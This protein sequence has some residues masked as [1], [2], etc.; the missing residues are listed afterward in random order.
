M[1]LERFKICS[2]FVSTRSLRIRGVFDES[3]QLSASTTSRCSQ[4]RRDFQNLKNALVPGPR[5]P[6]QPQGR[7]LV[8]IFTRGGAQNF[9]GAI[10]GTKT[11]AGFC[12]TCARLLVVGA[13]NW[14]D[15]S[16]TPRIRRDLVERNSEHILNRSSSNSKRTYD[17]LS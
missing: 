6:L 12:F 8:L 9:R 10:V 4:V 3:G 5:K 11:P 7:R 15:S 1:E 2:E 13:E 14:P 16:K 17:R